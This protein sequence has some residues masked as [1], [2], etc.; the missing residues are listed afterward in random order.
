MIKNR[1]IHIEK[2]A[3]RQMVLL[4]IFV[5]LQTI[6]SNVFGIQTP[7]MKI[8]FGFF[9]L[10]LA[11]MILGPIYAGIGSA[12]SDIIGFFIFQTGTFFPGYTLTALLC[13]MVYGFFLY[14][15]PKKLWR[16]I[17]SISLVKIVL[18]LG[19]NTYWTYYAFVKT[20][21]EAIFLKRVV[22]EL[23][24]IP[25]QVFFI[26]FLAYRISESPPALPFKKTNK[27]I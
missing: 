6:F 13:G 3:L 2:D 18:H 19:L 12:L 1:T 16:I 22:P 4:G 26:W 20:S 24:Q 27:Q 11:A 5:A 14:S 25:I 7:I 23:L 17:V 9:P 15:K 8:S 10:I 21:F